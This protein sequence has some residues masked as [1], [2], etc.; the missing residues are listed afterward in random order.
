M[1]RRVPLVLTAAFAVALVG[2][3]VWWTGRGGS[4]EL[5]AVASPSASESPR[6]TETSRETEGA[7]PSE[8]PSAAPTVVPPLTG[9]DAASSTI[10]GATVVITIA[11][12]SGEPASIL[13]GGFVSGIAEDGGQCRFVVTATD[14]GETASVEVPGSLN[15]DSTTCGSHEVFPPGSAAGEYT[16]R[17]EYSNDI[18]AASSAVFPV[19]E[20]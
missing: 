12:I 2:L 3:A 17:L 6:T 15:V 11:T 8:I 10:P 13:V 4:D 9:P 1:T 16:V 20:S 14:T 19:E 18:G 7:A 5:R